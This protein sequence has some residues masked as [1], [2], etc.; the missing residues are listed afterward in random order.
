MFMGQPQVFGKKY[1]V[2]EYLES[3]EK[4]EI[5]HEYYDGEIFAMAGTSM[6]HNEI[7]DNVRTLLKEFFRPKG[8]RVFAENI[9]VEAVRN[10]YYPYPD[11]VVT[12][13]SEDI[14]GT[15]VIKHPGI[16]VE[17]LSKSSGTYDREL[18]LRRYKEI[19][20]L[21]YYML[22][23]Q[24]DCYV[25]VY[26]RTDQERIWTY[27]SFD[28]PEAMINFELFGFSMPVAKVYQGIS[29]PEEEQRLFSEPIPRYSSV[30]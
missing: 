16:L 20:S 25:E 10:F 23:S 1:S 27:Q 11:V 18:K 13:A 3:E 15:Y 6:N 21:K 4:S 30:I 26:T 8:C 2:K 24:Y 28:S 14:N 9:K 7:V 22:V 19:P 29:F 17:V 5:R 12:C